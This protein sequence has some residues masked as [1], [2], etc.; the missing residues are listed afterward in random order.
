M[1]ELV[2][3][4]LGATWAAVLIPPL[5]RNRIENRPNSSVTDFRRQLNKLQST[6]PS[7][8]S[9]SMR[10]MARPLAQSP[11]HRPVAGGRPG[12]PAGQ[13]RRTGTRSH[14]DRTPERGT[15]I[16]AP[17][18]APR[19]RTHGDPTGG[20]RRPAQHRQAHV[21]RHSMTSADATRR[22]RS[23][24]MFLL[25]LAT[26][27]TLFLAATTKAPAMLYL[28]A[29]SFLALCGYVYLLTQMRQRDT[30]SWPNDWMH[31]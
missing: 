19:K 11:L 9:G 13:P 15:T 26:G 21:A 14:S 1:G 20:Q 30:S 3:L 17:R 8:A 24:V 16:T 27:S 31:R 29:F 23:N 28:F 6:V 4:V 7:R 2:L 12:L 25:V 10:G 22:R 18:E 5:L